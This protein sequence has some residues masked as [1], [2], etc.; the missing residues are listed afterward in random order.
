MGK[1]LAFLICLVLGAAGALV[2]YPRWGADLQRA[3]PASTPYL[4]PL[5]SASPSS[6]I[7][8]PPVVLIPVTPAALPASSGTAAPPAPPP[9][10]TLTGQPW[11]P[12]D[13]RFVLLA[14]GDDSNDDTAEAAAI[15]SGDDTRFPASAAAW[16]RTEGLRWGTIVS[17]AQ[18]ICAA[19]PPVTGPTVLPS[20]ADIQTAL[21]WFA[22]AAAGHRAWE[23]QHGRESWDD[24]WLAIYARMTAL[25]GALR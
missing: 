17:Q 8:P 6:A 18:G 7:S 14:M 9:P 2:T 22:D 19:I 12:A 20:A 15:V 3:L 24:A 11:S 25:Y 1:L 21:S 10:I 5:P 13:C 4:P 23:A 16:Y